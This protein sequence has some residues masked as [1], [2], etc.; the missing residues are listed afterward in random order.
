MGYTSYSLLFFLFGNS[1]AKNNR[2]PEMM[3]KTKDIGF[4]Q[5]K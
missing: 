3:A 4:W 5:N 1:T 2:K